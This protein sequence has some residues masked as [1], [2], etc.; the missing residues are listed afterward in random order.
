M[1]LTCADFRNLSEI[2]TFAKQRI[3]RNK[4]TR[5]LLFR[6]DAAAIEEYRQRLQHSLDVFGVRET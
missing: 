4:I 3:A 6:S 5:A 1:K 2:V